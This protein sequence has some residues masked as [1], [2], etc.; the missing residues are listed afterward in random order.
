MQVIGKA[1]DSLKLKIYNELSHASSLSCTSD[2]WKN[3]RTNVSYIFLTAHW[4]NENFDYK[5]RVLHCREMEGDHTGQNICNY[6]Q[7]MLSNLMITLNRV[8]VFLQDN[9][10]KI[11]LVISLLKSSS[12]PCF[13]HT[14]QLVIKDSLFVDDRR[15]LLLAKAQITVCH[16]SHSS[17]VSE[18]LKKS[19]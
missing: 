13:I 5:H 14:L 10:R 19:R 17:K 3:S 18:M 9:A 4:L 11:K 15:K 8:H 16:F 12:V 7:D 6:I 1:Y 2:M